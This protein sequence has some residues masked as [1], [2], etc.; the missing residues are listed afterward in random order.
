[1][2]KKEFLL[3][4]K[5]LVRKMFVEENHTVKETAKAFNC[6]TSVLQRFMRE[7]GITKKPMKKLEDLP[8]KENIK[9]LISQGLEYSDICQQLHITVDQLAKVLEIGRFSN[10]ID[11]S[12][13]AMDSPL[14]WY[15]LGLICS[16]GHNA[17]GD[18]IGI[19]QKDGTYLNGL[20]NLIGHQGTLYKAHTGYEL[21]IN[22]PKLSE[23]L[24]KYQINSD[25]RY[26]VPYIKAPT[27][28]LESCFIRGLFDGDGCIYY[29]YISGSFHNQRIEITSGSPN[30]MEG[31][32]DLY[33]RLSLN[34]TVD[35]RTSSANN[36]YYVIYVRATEDLINLGTWIYSNKFSFM[37][38][39]KRIKFLKFLDLL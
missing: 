25:K 30:M 31:L 38:K 19:Y 14:L 12:F 16:D 11:E 32:K 33:N 22:S 39:T 10:K 1:M 27:L 37:L 20:R 26:S 29:N 24:N 9:Q 8:T 17:A 28:E 15:L 4:N 36:P 35:C 7:E 3:Q 34:Y 21:H 5:E 6:S 13:I 18:S 2:L 23:I